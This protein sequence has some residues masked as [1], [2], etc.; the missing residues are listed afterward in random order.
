MQV[1]AVTLTKN[2]LLGSL[3]Y[4]IFVEFSTATPSL[5]HNSIAEEDWFQAWNMQVCKSAS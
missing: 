1:S 4:E 2:T 5:L 3:T